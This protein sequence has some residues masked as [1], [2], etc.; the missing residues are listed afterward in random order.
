MEEPQDRQPERD[1]GQSPQQRGE[2]VGKVRREEGVE[3]T[4]Y[5]A[6]EPASV[7]A[8]LVESDHA[9]VITDPLLVPPKRLAMRLRELLVRTVHSYAFAVLR[10]QAQLQDLPPP[11][12]L[13]GPDQDVVIVPVGKM[14]E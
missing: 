14:F 4:F 2:L 6:Q 13:S 8:G 3:F 1:E 5:D 12:L 7:A 11:R 10:L 9:L